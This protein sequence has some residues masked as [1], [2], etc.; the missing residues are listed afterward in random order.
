MNSPLG[1]ENNNLRR[2]A[3]IGWLDQ[4]HLNIQPRVDGSVFGYVCE[5]WDLELLSE[6]ISL[7][8]IQG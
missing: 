8:D 3:D 2:F 1:L 6:N 4:I 7:K 5:C